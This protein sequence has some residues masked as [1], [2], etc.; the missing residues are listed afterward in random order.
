MRRWRGGGRGAALL[1]LALLAIGSVLLG[2]ARDR[3]VRVPT[4]GQ[5]DNFDFAVAPDGSIHLVWTASTVDPERPWVR[6]SRIMYQRTDPG[7]GRWRPA[8][9]LAPGGAT[10][11]ILVADGRIHVFLGPGLTHFIS[12]DGGT[13]WIEAE[14][15]L[16]HGEL[17]RS[18]DALEEHGAIL[19]AY[20]S[21]DPTDGGELVV[22][23]VK[24]R[25]QRFQFGV[26]PQTVVIDSSDNAS[27]SRL[28][29][30]LLRS[31]GQ[32]LLFYVINRSLA[33]LHQI[34]PDE[35]LPRYTV[36]SDHG[37]TWSSPV[38]IQ[39]P[40][41]TPRRKGRLSPIQVVER[42]GEVLV[43]QDPM[44]FYRGRLGGT[45][46][47]ARGLNPFTPF[48]C[49]FMHDAAGASLGTGGQL[50]WLDDRYMRSPRKL[51]NP[52]TWLLWDT[53]DYG[54]NDVMSVP[55][56]RIWRGTDFDRLRP[57]RWTRSM[58]RVVSVEV[59]EFGG[60]IYAVWVGVD[61]ATWPWQLWRSPMAFHVV[62][63]PPE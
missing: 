29:I 8:V 17:A 13:T 50:F 39:V 48:R 27:P 16:P 44:S 3:I 1:A 55:L 35:E 53:P 54:N 34:P 22:P 60:Q 37:S 52:L 36:S 46:E 14:G 25:A 24:V 10:P 2:C 32:L 45:W 58:A 43:F 33:G 9:V 18:F 41:G 26:P 5:V 12:A 59:K 61:G 11:R 28:S 38:T 23:K 56:S 62:K 20:I 47:S 6:I 63:L 49:A 51:Y 19:L 31:G 21:N 57:R 30:R 7:E 15:V 40:P 4:P 42:E